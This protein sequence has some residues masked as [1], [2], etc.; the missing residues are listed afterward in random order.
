MV[1]MEAVLYSAPSLCPTQCGCY[2]LVHYH[3][4]A[5]SQT[6]EAVSAYF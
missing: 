4:E 1:D 2:G 6:S 3:G 5:E